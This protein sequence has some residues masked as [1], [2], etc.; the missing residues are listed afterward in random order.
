MNE[1]MTL[2]IKQLVIDLGM[3]LVGIAST[4]AFAPAPRGHRPQDLLNGARSVICMALGYASAAFENA[5][6]REYAISFM[7]LNRELD[8]CAF[9]I[10]RF[11]QE[12]GQRAIQIPASPPYDL[13]ANRGDLSHKHAGCLSG[14]GVF[15]KNDLLL[16]PQ[17]GAHMRLVSVVTEARLVADH[18]LETDLCGE[19]DKCL[20]ACP[21]QALPGNR[22]VDKTK[23]DAQHVKVAEQLQLKEWEDICG[24]CIRVC[25]VGKDIAGRA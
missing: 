20:K 23:C 7:V 2:E 6:S 16:S 1:D 12:R 3:D 13:I 19:C 18:P 15:G 24:V 17:F 22:V 4:E 25:P 21:A 11:L 5:P 8:R 10:T 9:R 14:I